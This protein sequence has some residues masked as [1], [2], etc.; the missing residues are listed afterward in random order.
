[1]G[2]VANTVALAILL[3][4]RKLVPANQLEWG[5][6]AKSGLTACIAGVLS[7]EVAKLVMTGNSRTADMKA[8]AL[9]S[10]TWAAAVAAGLWITKSKLPADLRR[11]K[12][13]AYP[14]VAE[15]GGAVNT[16]IEP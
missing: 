3:H 14:R 12:P 1:V 6:V 4:L 16:G 10:I 15:A 13:T 7:F 9:I 2:I 5:E 11:R 8:L